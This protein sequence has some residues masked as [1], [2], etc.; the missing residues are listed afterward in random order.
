MWIIQRLPG[1]N[2]NKRN[3]TW[4]VMRH[5]YEQTASRSIKE[6]QWRRRRRRQGLWSDAWGH[7]VW[8][9]GR[10]RTH[11]ST[12]TPPRQPP[13][14]MCGLSEKRRQITSQT[15]KPRSEDFFFCATTVEKKKE[16]KNNNWDSAA[17]NCSKIPPFS[18][19][20]LLMRPKK[21]KKG[22]EEEEMGGRRQ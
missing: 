8:L 6:A 12:P 19:C 16:K 20:E 9:A 7:C 18:L 15:T 5:K 4:Q 13:L 17:A 1:R 10:R 22:E 14:T 2:A 11:P 3:K 21:D